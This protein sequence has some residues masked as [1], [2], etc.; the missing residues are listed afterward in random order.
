[1]HHATKD[2][3]ASDAIMRRCVSTLINLSWTDEQ[4]KQ[5]GEGIV[6][7]LKKV[8]TKEMA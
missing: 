7:A 8:L 6:A 1:M 5:K 3:S 4:L 2:F